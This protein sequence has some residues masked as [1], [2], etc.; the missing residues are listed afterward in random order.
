MEIICLLENNTTDP[1]LAP[2]HG[3]SFFIRT[4]T[5]SILFDMG[6]D[7]KFADNAR[8]LGVDLGQADLAVLSH[9][10]YDHGGGLPLFQKLNSKARTIMTRKAI[11]GQYYA[12][13][14]KYEPKYIGLDAQAID[15][16]RCRFIDSDLALSEEL[17]IITDFSKNGFVPQGNAGLLRM[18]KD[19]RLIED[20]F[21]H[22]LAL[23]IEENGTTVLFTGCAHSGMGNMIDTVLTRT[24]RDHIDH[25]IGGFHLYNRV[26][27]I[28]EADSRLDILA[29]ELSSHH[30]TTYYTGHCTGPD[31]P[32]Y[33]SRK[34][35]RPIH[36]FATGTRIK[37]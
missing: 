22:E 25:V 5:R 34:M 3:L 35:G 9:G 27:R 15:Q 17:T 32:G 8:H 23:L 33:M 26:T 30:R 37:I 13:Y 11:E 29:H 31:A 7:S 12:R 16:S 19:G 28:S 6:Q 4:R 36:V 1:K 18:Q 2:A 21:F 20:E 24:G 10:H 14:L